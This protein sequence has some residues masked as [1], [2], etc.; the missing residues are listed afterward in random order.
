MTTQKNLTSKAILDNYF[1]K[2]AIRI[3]KEAFK[4]TLLEPIVDT[5]KYN[6]RSFI[7]VNRKHFNPMDYNI[8]YHEH[9]YDGA[10]CFIYYNGAWR[11][12]IFNEDGK[13]NCGNIANYYGGSG[14]ERNATFAVEDIR[15][16]FI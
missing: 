11:F 14:T 12:E 3:Y 4:I 7:C 10:A 6:R 5:D 15:T 9:G 1:H 8:N 16:I 2:T 13:V